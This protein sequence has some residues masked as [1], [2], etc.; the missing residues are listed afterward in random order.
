MRETIT[1]A[2]CLLLIFMGLQTGFLRTGLDYDNLQ[3]KMESLQ[4]VNDR[5]SEE[6]KTAPG[7]GSA[8]AQQQL[9]EL[10]SEVE[11]YRNSENGTHQKIQAQKEQWLKIFDQEIKD[12]ELEIR[13]EDNNLVVTA[14]DRALFQ[15]ESEKISRNAQAWLLKLAQEIRDQKDW[16]IRILGHTDLIVNGKN[17]AEKNSK[18]RAWALLRAQVLGDFLDAQG[19][20]DPVQIIAASCGASRPLVS[21]DSEYHRAQNR[22]F[23]FWFSSVNPRGMNQSRKIARF[24]KQLAVAAPPKSKTVKSGEEETGGAQPLGAE[25]LNQD[26]NTNFNVGYEKPKE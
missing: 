6:L 15:G 23:E 4:V 14:R 9:D 19:G 8:G 16:E 3:K 22:R 12:G 26:D 18:F 24:E 10:K 21:N 25:S 5:L 7:A 11:H 13:D 1:I 20:V 2:V 17:A